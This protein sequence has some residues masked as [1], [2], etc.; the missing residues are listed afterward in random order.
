MFIAVSPKLG[1]ATFPEFVTLAKSKPGQIAVGTNGAGTL[2]T[3]RP[4]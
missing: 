1:V 3:F 4:G 2:P